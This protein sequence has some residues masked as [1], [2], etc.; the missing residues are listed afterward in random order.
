MRCLVQPASK[1]VAAVALLALAACGVPS[2][3][4]VATAYWDSPS[5]EQRLELVADDA[6]F[7][8]TN[9]IVYQEL[10]VG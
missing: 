5:L 3:E 7:T 6:V 1:G 10:L 2:T 9:G 8:S 4:E